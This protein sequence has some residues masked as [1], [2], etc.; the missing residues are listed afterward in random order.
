MHVSRRIASRSLSVATKVNT[1]SEEP[2]P[3]AGERDCCA[4]EA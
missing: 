4:F 2:D 1:N 3:T